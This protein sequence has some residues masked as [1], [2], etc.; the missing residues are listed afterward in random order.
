MFRAK[1]G[2]SSYLRVVPVPNT[3][4]RA[5]VLFFLVTHRPAVRLESR[6]CGCRGCEHQRMAVNELR[7]RP[8]ALITGAGRRAGIAAACVK[9]LALDGFDVAWTHWSA[10]DARMPWGAD[11]E[12]VSTLMR[13]VEDAGVR[14]LSIEV[15][16][17]T[18]DAAP[19]VF[20]A[21]EESLGHAPTCLVLCHAES[22]DSGLL[23][24]TE[25]ALDMH[26]AVN[27]RATWGLVREFGMRFDPAP[28]GGRIVAMTSDHTVGN[29]PYGATKAALDRIVIA[30]ARE[31]AHLQ[32]TANVINPGATDTGWMD[33]DLMASM[34]AATPLRRVGRPED[35]ANLVS[36]LC[37]PQGGWVNGQLLMSN[38]G[39][40]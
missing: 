18:S 19:A 7:H 33:D 6:Q 27:V 34:A 16:L 9:R 22:V 13:A 25:A 31:L 10:Y 29:L 4:A 28:E 39:A 17:A 8:L 30:A 3:P 23:E 37:S 35:A 32:V 11:E 2:E 12:A 20:D 5:Q 38:G 21:V 36:F 15:D 14:G 40:A 1:T 24:T 26:Y